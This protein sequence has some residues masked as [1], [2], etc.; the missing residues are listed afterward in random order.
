MLRWPITEQ[1]FTSS[2]KRR[3][4]PSVFQWSGEG[5]EN[6]GEATHF[7]QEVSSPQLSTPPYTP[8]QSSSLSFS[9]TPAQVVTSVSIRQRCR[10]SDSWR[11]LWFALWWRRTATGSLWLMCRSWIPC[12]NPPCSSPKSW[13]RFWLGTRRTACRTTWAASTAWT[14]P[15]TGLRYG[16]T[17]QIAL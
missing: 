8:S 14:T 15:R 12:L 17:L 10:L 4:H 1:F 2:A 3:S 11:W 13:S 5:C 16:E 7:R 6:L 9:H